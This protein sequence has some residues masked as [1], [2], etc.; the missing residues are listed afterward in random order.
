VTPLVRAFRRTGADLPGTDPRPTHRAEMEGWFWRITDRERGR[1]ALALCGINRHPDGDWATVAVAAHPGRVVR[2]AVVHEGWASDERFDVRVGDVL[3]ADERTL[4]VSVGDARLSVALHDVVGWPH[5]LGA[6][7]LAAIVPWLGQYWHPHVLG[8]RVAG[9]LRVGDDT[10]DLD[11]AD[12]YAEKNWGGGFPDRWW[13]GQAQGFARRDLCVAFGGGRLPVGPVGV[14]VTGVVL[15]VGDDV[16][17]FVPPVALIRTDIGAGEWRLDARRLGWRLRIE[18]DAAGGAPT[19]LPVPVPAERRNVDRDLEHLAGRMR[20]RVWRGRR[21]VVDDRSDLAALEV[22]S[23][24][25]ARFAEL[26]DDHPHLDPGQPSR[27]SSS[28][29][30]A[31]MA[32]SAS[33]VAAPTSA[34]S[35]TGRT[36]ST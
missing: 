19:V 30:T 2:P 18:G 11:G 28:A 7:G 12:V 34:T 8:G 23:L 31:S 13:W 4:E 36:T 24:D 22:G 29:T 3:R 20:L 26:V 10:W 32:A 17:R 15:R 1:V 9:S 14:D 16:V 35:P 25:P 6:G 33:R 5:R 27:A 21:L